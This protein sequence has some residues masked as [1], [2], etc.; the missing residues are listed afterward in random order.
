V[1]S[2]TRREVRRAPYG[3]NLA[4]MFSANRVYSERGYTPVGTEELELFWPRTGRA[5]DAKRTIG[6]HM[7]IDIYIS[8][9]GGLLGA[10]SIGAKVTELGFIYL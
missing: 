7:F 4:V 5:S 9:P 8:Q 3:V 2:W 10:R 6:D 1:R